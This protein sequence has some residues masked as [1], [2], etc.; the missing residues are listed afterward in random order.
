MKSDYWI[1]CLTLKLPLPGLWPYSASTLFWHSLYQFFLS[2]LMP[3]VTANSNVLWDWESNQAWFSTCSSC[4]LS[5]LS[6][7]CGFV[8]RHIVWWDSATT[9]HTQVFTELTYLQNLPELP[10]TLEKRSVLS[11]PWG[12]FQSDL[13]QGHLPLFLGDPLLSHRP[14]FPDL[15]QLPFS[16][17]GYA[18][19]M[20]FHHETESLTS[21]HPSTPTPLSQ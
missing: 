9:K 10:G 12:L 6:D 21:L 17:L 4:L 5:I 14:S 1:K 7:P 20:F 18:H 15:L 13:Q 2:T 8:V 3:L 19:L 11:L 16:K